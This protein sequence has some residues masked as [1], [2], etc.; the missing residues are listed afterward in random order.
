M[1][2]VLAKKH[3]QA[4]ELFQKS[5][6]SLSN[7]EIARA[8]D[9]AES[10]VRKWKSRYKWLEQ[11]GFKKNVTV[12]SVT[13]NEVS[14]RDIQRKRIVDALIEAGTYSPA[15]DLLLEIYLDAYSEYQQLREEGTA[16]EKN[17]RELARLLNQ[18]GLD[19]KNKEL[20]KKSGILLGVESTKGEGTKG[21]KVEPEPASDNK[22]IDFRK[23]KRG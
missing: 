20:V 14:E 7:A 22:L 4:F 23:R 9:A 8:V 15:F 6:G 18:L 3:E 21:K 19:G 2:K 16:D 11:I 13:K 17:R 10:T 12:T 1:N 5:E